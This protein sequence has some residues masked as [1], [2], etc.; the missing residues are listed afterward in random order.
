MVYV[1]ITQSR[2]VGWLSL[3]LSPSFASIDPP[4]R[5]FYFSAFSFPTLNSA[6]LTL[7]RSDHGCDLDSTAGRYLACSRVLRSGL[8]G[9]ALVCTAIRLSASPDTS[10][11]ALVFAYPSQ[12]SECS[13]CSPSVPYPGGS[14][15]VSPVRANLP[16]LNSGGNPA[17]DFECRQYPVRLRF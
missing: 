15:L 12:G 2:G 3:P 10:N 9:S 8:A 1:S 16:R 4:L 6:L 17:E 14:G 5:S 13:C 11:P 7:P